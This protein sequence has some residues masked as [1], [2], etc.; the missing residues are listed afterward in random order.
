MEMKY[1]KL[2][3]LVI[4]AAV[5][6]LL[7]YHYRWSDYIKDLE[8]IKNLKAMVHNNFW[9]AV[10][11]YMAVTIIGC[12][13]LAIPGITFSIFAGIIFGPWIGAILCLIATTI[14]ASIAF[15]ISRF[16]MKDAVKPMLEK[17][18]HLKKLLFES[19]SKNQIIS[20]L[21]TRV[22]PIFPYNIQ[23][24]AYGITNIGFW[25]YTIF[26]FIFMVPGISLI[27]IGSSV[28]V[29]DP[30]KSIYFIIALLAAVSISMLVFFMYRK[31]HGSSHMKQT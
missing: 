12:V 27:T 1:K 24:F 25:K 17:H 23:N 21:I 22:V 4:I 29:T 10:L 11:I 20:L 31:F 16:F 7:N 2:I 30:S 19:S 13:A 26:T 8:N 5:I 14:S 18:E 28:I 3:A 15:L 9:H 6:I